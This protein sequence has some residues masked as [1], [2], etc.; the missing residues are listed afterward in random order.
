MSGETTY[1]ESQ[2]TIMV[3]DMDEAVRFYTE[4]LRLR[5][6]S[7]YGNEFAVIEAPGLTI[8]LHPQPAKPSAQSHAVSIG[9][10]VES[11]EPAMEELKARTGTGNL[12][13]A[14]FALVESAGIEEAAV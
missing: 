7:R 9:L 1:S 6:K 2:I 14:F 12:R 8:G 13:E 10:G 3:P 4:K 5:L 11:L